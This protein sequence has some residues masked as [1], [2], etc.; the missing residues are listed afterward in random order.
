[1]NILFYLFSTGAW[2]AAALVAHSKNPIHSVFY[3]VL[4]FCNASAL[5][6]MLGMEFFALLQLLVYVGALAV[7]FL[8]VV[9]LLDITYTEIV[10][11]QRGYYPIA[12]VLVLVFLGVFFLLFDQTFGHN[13][14]L[15]VP[16]DLWWKTSNINPV[17]VWTEWNTLL[18]SIQ[19]IQAL[20]PILYIQYVDLLILASLILLVA[21]I[22]AVVLTLKKR[23]DA[24]LPDIFSQHNRDFKRVVYN[25]SSHL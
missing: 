10:A 18:Q 12:I 16:G 15:L 4:V 23:A 20:S 22:G 19:N 6:L 17:F 21:M 8:F 14:I 25:I 11:H 24:P 7:M 5:L 1:M 13:T 3:L 2:I 9:M